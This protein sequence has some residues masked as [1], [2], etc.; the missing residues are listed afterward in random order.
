MAAIF[1]GVFFALAAGVFAYK[2]ILFSRKKQQVSN[3]LQN[4]LPTIEWSAVQHLLD[5]A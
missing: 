4:N 2:M 1:A 5:E 3:S